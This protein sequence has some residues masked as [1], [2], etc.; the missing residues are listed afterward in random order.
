[1][2]LNFNYKVYFEEGCLSKARIGYK[3]VNNQFSTPQWG[4]GYYK[5]R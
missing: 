3:W 4:V 5:R 1:M 2:A